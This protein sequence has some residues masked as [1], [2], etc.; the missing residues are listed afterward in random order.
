MMNG[1]GKW[2]AFVF[3]VLATAGPVLGAGTWNL[4][5]P[6]TVMLDNDLAT[7]GDVADGPVPAGVRDLVIRAGLQPNSV[8][9]VSRQ[10][11]LR[12][13]VTAG[14]ARGVRLLGASHSHLIF[15]GRELDSGEI[16]QEVRRAIQPLVPSSLAGAPDSWFELDLP[17]IELAAAG[18][19][20]VEID[21][22]EL[23][24]PGRNLIRISVVD[25]DRKESFPVSVTLHQFG[26]VGRINHDLTR[27]MPLEENMFN[28]QWKDLANLDNGLAVQRTSIQGAS[29]TRN[30]KAGDY[31]RQADLKKTPIILA[32]DSVELRVHRG[33]VAVTVRAFA[34][35][36]G[37]LGQTIPVRNEL[38]GRLVNARV[39]GPGLVEWRR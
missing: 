29:P 36:N 3:V 25:G 18:S 5:L 33:Q 37:C 16:H 13:L 2:M 6:D 35:Q 4:V 30:L 12:R 22:T 32:G 17:K 10:D 23:I 24:E 27:N 19:W 21:R 26:E 8:V 7:L 39:A 34:R 38:T 15:A 31:L 11:I 9:E 20:H 28:W 14:Q 1:N